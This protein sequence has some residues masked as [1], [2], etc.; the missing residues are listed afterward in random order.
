MATINIGEH[1]TADI[2]AV[3]FKQMRRV[4]LESLYGTDPR[5]TLISHAFL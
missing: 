2:K 4:T 3:F 1:D 5:E